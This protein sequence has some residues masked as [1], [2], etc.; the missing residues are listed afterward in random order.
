[1]T[2][3]ERAKLPKPTKRER[4]SASLVTGGK[5]VVSSIPVVGGPASELIGAIAAPIM[6][7][8]RDA[9]FETVGE[10]VEEL[11]QR[12]HA[13]EP[14]QLMQ[15]DVFVTAVAHATQIA[16]RTHQSEKLEALRNAVLNSALPGAPEDD[17]QLIFLNLVD[18]STPTHLR[19]LR[20]LDDPMAWMELHGPTPPAG[21]AGTGMN[22]IAYAFP[23]L[24][25]YESVY[26][27]IP[28]E[29][30]NRGLLDPCWDEMFTFRNSGSFGGT[31]TS[32]L[33]KAFL[34][35]STSPLNKE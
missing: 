35:F 10:M 4:L 11:G 30:N 14:E 16:L 18:T 24:N 8:R 13:L 5:I 23:E 22:L 2:D 32:P 34:A 27:V 15:N 31:R 28:G 9:W 25:I 29:L 1:M 19:I 26:R 6:N 33:G 7:K 21:A 20:F 3:D 12:I 17:L